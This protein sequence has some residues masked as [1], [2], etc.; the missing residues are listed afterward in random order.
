MRI[1]VVRKPEIGNA[2]PLAQ[3]IL[4]LAEAFFATEEGEAEYQEYLRQKAA[5]GNA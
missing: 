2:R 1:E 5:G 4:E 3:H